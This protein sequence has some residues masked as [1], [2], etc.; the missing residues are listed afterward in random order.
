MKLDVIVPSYN[1]EENVVNFYEKVNEALGDIKHNFIFVDDGSKDKTLKKLKELHEKDDERVK[2]VSFSKNFGKEAAIYAGLL[3]STSDYACIID[4]DLQQNPNYMVKMYK[5]LNENPD[6]DSVCMCQKQHKKR[7]LQRCFYNIMGKLSNMNIVDGASDFRM[8]RR[9]MV[10]S[11]VSLDERNRFSKGIF[12]WVG[13]NTEYMYY[14]V[15]RRF[16]GKTKF[17]TG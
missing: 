5:F 7:F 15:E 9:N 12:S 6:Y 11:I 16:S 17:T 13:F 14:N 1:E 2:I 8:F 10:N 3:H 4:C